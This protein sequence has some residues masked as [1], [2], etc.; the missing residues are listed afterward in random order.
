MRLRRAYWT[1]SLVVLALPLLAAN[2]VQNILPAE[3]GPFA[4]LFGAVVDSPFGSG[5]ASVNLSQ[6]G[7]QLSGTYV[8]SVSGTSTNF[9]LKQVVSGVVQLADHASLVGGNC[10]DLVGTVS[11]KAVTCDSLAP[12][13]AVLVGVVSAVLES[14]NNVLVAAGGAGLFQSPGVRLDRQ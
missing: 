3:S 11:G 12:V 10:H 13:A 9:V 7:D 1:L 4:G 5:V 14:D 2:C 8:F 6:A